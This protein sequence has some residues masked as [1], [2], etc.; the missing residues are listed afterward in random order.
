MRENPKSYM[1]SYKKWGGVKK[2]EFYDLSKEE[3]SINIFARIR[4]KWHHCVRRWICEVFGVL[5]FTEV[6]K[7]GNKMTPLLAII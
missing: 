1:I 4:M 7:F 3:V 2:Y 5:D 6:W